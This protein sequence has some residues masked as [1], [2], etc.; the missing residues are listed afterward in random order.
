MRALVLALVAALALLL[1]AGAR[2]A[3]ASGVD[4]VSDQN[5]GLWKGDFTTASNLADPFPTYFAQAWVG[6]PASHLR[7]ARFVTAPDTI[8]QGGACEQN[9][10]NWY[11]YVTQTLHMIPVIGVWQVAEGGCA[12]NG[13]PSSAKYTSEIAQLLAA[14]HAT[15]TALPYIEAWNEPNSSGVSASAAAAFWRDAATD[16]V[17]AGCTALAGDFVDNDPNQGGQAFNPGCTANL[18]YSGVFKSYESA[19]VKALNGATPSI[20]ALHPYYAVNCAQSASITTFAAGLPASS[21]A[22]QIWFTEV[23]AWECRLGQTTARGPAVQQT[24]ANYLASVLSPPFP[25]LATHTF[26]Y[27]LAV[28]GW[29]QNCAKYADSALYE[30]AEPL[31]PLQARPAA[32][33]VFGL[34]N[35]L[36]AHTGAASGL[37][38]GGATLSGTVTPGGIYEATEYFQYGRT[39]SY[40]SQTTA[41]ALGPGLSPQSV[42][43]SISGLSPGT[44]YHYRVFAVDTAG[45][46][47][48][49]SDATFTTPRH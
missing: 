44:L 25:V 48:P 37:S 11:T 15:G 29:T 32:A 28:L 47:S 42:S 24:D 1:L 30:A 3:A 46:T 33:S 40:S 23:G 7:Y 9:L 5:L 22:P 38:T 13:V 12:D 27:E 41:V 36:A 2:S 39:A 17:S 43:A 14:L 35:T 6:S 10:L 49:G 20:W 26:W 18:S 16:C 21:P 34:D 45:H 4:G 31:G 8:A 19:Y